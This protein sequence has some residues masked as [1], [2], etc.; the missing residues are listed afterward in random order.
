MCTCSFKC[1]LSPYYIW[2]VP[3]SHVALQLRVFSVAYITGSS[4]L[5]RDCHTY[6]A[7]NCNFAVT[8]LW[9]LSEWCSICH[10]SPLWLS[11][12]SWSGMK[13]RAVSLQS[14]SSW[15]CSGGR[16]HPG[17]QA[18]STGVGPTP[19]CR[20]QSSYWPLSAQRELEDWKG[21]KVTQ[22]C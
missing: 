2:I 20:G 11:S 17:Q 10:F 21:L 12:S 18:C 19:P 3:E 8:N 22:C 16:E 13:R 9:T 7:G 4:G 5:V 15:P 6:G 14:S 1:V